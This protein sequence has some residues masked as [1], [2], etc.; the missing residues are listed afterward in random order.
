M[1]V[2]VKTV[3]L[4]A[5]KTRVVEE[6]SPDAMFL[7]AREGAFISEDDAARYGVTGATPAAYDAAAAHA[8]RH[9]GETQEEADRRRAAM[10]EGAVAPDGEKGLAPVGNKAI[11]RAPENK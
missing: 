11:S 6:G 8:I 7:L 5:D 1:P 2:A 10:L 4:N 3:Y 9:A